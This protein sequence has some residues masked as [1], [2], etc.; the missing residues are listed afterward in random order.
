MSTRLDAYYLQGRR[1]FWVLWMRYLEG[2]FTWEWAAVGCVKRKGVGEREA[3]IHLLLEYW[4]F[5]AGEDGLD[6]FHWINEAAYLSVADV[7]AIAREVWGSN[8]P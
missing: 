6:H 7:M 5:Q 2:R 3:A 8:D 1:G 4:K